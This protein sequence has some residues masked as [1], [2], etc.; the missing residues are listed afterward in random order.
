[1][2]CCITDVT[3]WAQQHFGKPP[4]MCLQTTPF[5]FYPRAAK[6]V[7][8]AVRHSSLIQTWSEA[9]ATRKSSFSLFDG[10]NW[11]H[12]V[13]KLKILLVWLSSSVFSLRCRISHPISSYT[14]HIN[15]V[16]QRSLELSAEYKYTTL[17]MWKE[18]GL[19]LCPIPEQAGS[20]LYF[21][22]E[23]EGKM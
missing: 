22:G 10:N 19:S 18:K 5:C 17:F 21:D 11:G 2:Q 7:R 3:T 9:T 23:D 12:K 4:S 20:L 8:T 6:V 16:T 1:M 13:A 14:S 15:I